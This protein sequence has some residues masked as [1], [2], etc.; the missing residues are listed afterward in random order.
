MLSFLTPLAL[1]IALAVLWLAPLARHRQEALLH[2]CRV[3]DN[4]ASLGC[5]SGVCSGVSLQEVDQGSRPWPAQPRRHRRSRRTRTRIRATRTSHRRQGTS[6]Q[7]RTTGQRTCL[8]PSRT[9]SGSNACTHAIPTQEALSLRRAPPHR[10]PPAYR[11]CW[12][13]VPYPASGGRIHAAQ[14]RRLREFAPMTWLSRKRIWMQVWRT[15]RRRNATSTTGTL[16]RRRRMCATG[17]LE[18]SISSQVRRT[19]RH[20]LQTPRYA[21]SKVLRDMR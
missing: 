5:V 12:H 4:W 21:V 9:D 19:R 14:F 15:C 1:L 7:H 6:H 17:T 10:R 8:A 18:A 11:F 13:E 2:A 20:A 16:T 3:L